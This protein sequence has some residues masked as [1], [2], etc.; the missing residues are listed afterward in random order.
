[1]LRRTPGVVILF[2]IFSLSVVLTG[3]GGG[4]TVTIS[5]QPSAP[6]LG[7]T[8][9]EVQSAV[10]GAATSVDAAVVIAVTD[11]SGQVLAVFQKSGASATAVGNFSANVATTELA[12]ALARTAA[13]FS[14]DQAP[15][16]SR[17]VRFI[18]GIHFPP[19]IGNTASAALYGIENTNRGCPLTAVGN[20]LP[21]KVITPSFLIGGSFPG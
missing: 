15:L 10:Q 19:G 21:G 12:V 6:L 7:L 13:Y 16:S 9:A 2:S 3:C 20:F 14:N 17:T 18:S 8:A 11:R 4:R 1:M 5:A